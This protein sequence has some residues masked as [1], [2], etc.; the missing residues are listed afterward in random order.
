MI[1]LMEPL[2]DRQHQLLHIVWP[3]FHQNQ[4]FPVFH[5]VDYKMRELGWDAEEVINSFPVIGLSG[6]GSHYGAVWTNWPRGGVA[7]RDSPVCLSMAG[8]F[9]IK[10]Q[11]TVPIIRAVLI[12]LSEMSAAQVQI[13]DHPYRV[14]RIQVSLK[15]AL[16]AN[17]VDLAIIPWVAPVVQHEWLAMQV[18]QQDNMTDVTGELRLLAKADFPTI[19]SYL[20]A[21]TAVTT[22]QQPPPILGY[23]DPRALARTITNFDIT[24]ELVLNAPLVKKPAIDR[25]ALFAQEVAT[26]TDLQ[27]G[28]SA[29]GELMGD[30]QVPGKNPSHPTDRLLEYLVQKVPRIDKARVQD[31]LDLMD[32]VRQIR[33]SGVHP[34]P[35]ATLISAHNRLGLPFPVRDPAHAWN[36]IRGQIDS[37]FG[38]LQEEIYAAR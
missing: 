6:P 14:P 24:C 22:P 12:F 27:A 8:L 28:V 31:A 5:Y 30:L 15:Q 26:Y 18:T 19:E 38:I 37:A 10:D 25:T 20:N 33:N 7:Q 3:L 17:D 2:E 4:R 13:A 34:K 1:S 36:I 32:A 11:E 35:S 21:I 29:L 23:R 9:H 16:K